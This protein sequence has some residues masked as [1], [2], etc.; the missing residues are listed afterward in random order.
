MGTTNKAKC[1]D[2]QHEFEYSEGGGFTFAIINCDSCFR[3][4]SVSW[5]E[6]KEKETQGLCECGG[7]FKNSA[8]PRCDKCNSANIQKLNVI[9]F[10]D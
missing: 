5:E 8:A 6:K 3:A 1:L 7:T 9:V 4:K 10:F 2:C